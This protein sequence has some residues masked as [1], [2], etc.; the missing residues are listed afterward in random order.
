M[1]E[2]I[3]QLQFEF[4]KSRNLQPHHKLLDLGCGCFRAGVHLIDYLQSGQYFGIDISQEL[5]D[6]GYAKE[7][8]PLGLDKKLP[9]TNLLCSLD[10][11]AERFGVR[12]DMA[13]AQSVFTHLSFNHLRQCLARL[14]PAM[15][16]GAVF[17]ITAFIC[18]AE[19]DATCPIKHDPGGI[20]TSPVSDPFHYQSDDFQY[21]AKGLPW[22]VEVIG[23][24]DHPR[25]QS[26]VAFHRLS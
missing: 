1:W 4:L 11:E 6:A 14:A 2:E 18:P 22:R 25:N 5:L 7:L 13:I 16:A 17:Y 12:F 23:N 15:N 24:W 21:A 9:P 10:F 19:K 26:M 8:T 20:V 3:G